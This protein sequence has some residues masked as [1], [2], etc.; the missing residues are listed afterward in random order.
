MGDLSGTRLNAVYLDGGTL[1]LPATFASVTNRLNQSRLVFNGGVLQTMGGGLD[2]EISTDYLRGL[3]QAHV[4]P[5]GAVVDTQGRSVTFAQ[6]LTA[7]NGVDDGGLIKRGYGTLTLAKP[8]CVTGVVDVQAGMLT[9]K[10]ESG[11]AY[12]DDPMVRFTFENGVQTDDSAYEKNAGTTTGTTNGLSLIAGVKGTNA[13]HF[14]GSNA[15]YVNYSDDMANMDTYTVSA[16]VRM[17]V[18]QSVNQKKTFFGTLPDYNLTRHAF[19][20]RV[21]ENGDFRMLGAG[22]FSS[23]TGYGQLYAD[24]LGAVPEN[25]WVMLTYVADGLNGISMYVNGTNREMRVYNNGA[26]TYTNA[27]GAGQHWLFQPTAN[28]NGRAFAMGAVTV[29]ESNTFSGDL[30]DVTVYRRALSAAELSMLYRSHVPYERRV[31]VAMGA[32]LNLAG[33]TQEVAEVTGEGTVLDGTASVTHALNPGDAADTPA[34]AL[35]VFNGGLTLGAHVTYTCDWT[36]AANDLVD[37]W[38]TLCVDG[39]GTIDLGLTLPSQMPGSPRYKSFPVMYYT[40]IVG[41]SNFSQWKVSGTGRKVTGSIS[42]SD[43]V[44][45]VNLDVPSGSVFFLR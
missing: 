18:Y 44:V 12:P 29:T 28:A 4:G 41:A 26:I 16:W 24:V 1:R 35:L 40:S 34:G 25:T 13:V 8:P 19:L 2:P 15:P 3:K 20:L 9:L 30:D 23:V 27:Y 21:M 38:G 14:A 37:I 7:Q 39:A 6:R 43:G 22:P 31:R 32:N 5:R 36:P 42:A 45:T 11:V 10:P 33:V 17:P